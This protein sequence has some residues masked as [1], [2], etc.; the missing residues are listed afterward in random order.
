MYFIIAM[1]WNPVF[2]AARL[3]TRAEHASSVED[4]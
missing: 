3:F 1:E 2:E 4:T